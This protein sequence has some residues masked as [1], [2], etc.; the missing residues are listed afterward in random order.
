M[1]EVNVAWG[2]I[3]GAR[4]GRGKFLRG[5]NS[6]PGFGH[7]VNPRNPAHVRGS[8]NF[9]TFASVRMNKNAVIP[10]GVVTSRRGLPK[11]HI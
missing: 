10:S 3:T 2:G 9:A 4:G 5:F 8:R 7:A 6:S 1:S 11:S